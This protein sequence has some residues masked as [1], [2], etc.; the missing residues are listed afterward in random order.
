MKKVIM[1]RAV[2]VTR[3]PQTNANPWGVYTGDVAKTDVEFTVEGMTCGSC[4]ARVEK[5]LAAQPGVEEAAVNF[6]T[7]RA[8]VVL[9]P[10][11]GDPDRLVDAVGRI[12]YGLA[13]TAAGA[14][15]A[16]DTEAGLQATW[17]RRVRWWLR[18][19]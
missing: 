19:R 2:P 16:P 7:G 9:D 17:L 10:E 1:P 6:A 13:P 4:A 8:V 12:G 14:L 3:G 18:V 5:A 15:A 11:A